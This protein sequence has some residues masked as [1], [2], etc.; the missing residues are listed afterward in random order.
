[1]LVIKLSIPLID[2]DCNPL[3]DGDLF[4][5]RVLNLLKINLNNMY[6]C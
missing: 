4:D 6:A 5:D 2:T 1:M 3:N